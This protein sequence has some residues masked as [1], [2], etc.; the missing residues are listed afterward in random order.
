MQLNP[1][2]RDL[3]RFVIDL[4]N[5]PPTCAEEL[6]E[7]CR[8][9]G[10]LL[11]DPVTDTDLTEVL[12]FLARWAEVVDAA[13]D[14]RRAALLNELLAEFAEHPRLT[15]HGGGIWHIHYR[16]DDRTPAGVLCAVASVGTALHLTSLGMHR[17]GRCALAD[18]RRA[19][20]DFSR[21]GR[22]RYC[23]P[24][25]ANRDAVRRHRARRAAMSR[26]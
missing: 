4:T 7:R 25:C 6:A 9:G 15:D 22:Q 12:A 18:C 19:Y 26:S 8:A 20:A 24:A 5:T 14:A 11:E 2:G 1:Y 23:S 10:M 16:D 17:L 21:A 3:V 13:T